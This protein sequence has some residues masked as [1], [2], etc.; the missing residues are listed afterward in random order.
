KECD[1]SVLEVAKVPHFGAMSF[2]PL[3]SLELIYAPN[4]VARKFALL[5]E[6]KSLAVHFYPFS[7]PNAMITDAEGK[8]EIY[9]KMIPEERQATIIGERLDLSVD[10]TQL[11]SQVASM[12]F[13]K[14][15]VY[16]EVINDAA[17]HW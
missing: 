12:L 6:R 13:E 14:N 17:D 11:Y 3:P 9:V 7:R 15:I 4:Y 10:P 8:V 16:I 2:D 1:L 5:E